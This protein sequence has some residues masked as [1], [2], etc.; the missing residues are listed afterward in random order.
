M[1]R[2]DAAAV[3][4]GGAWLSSPFWLEFIDP[5]YQFAL[6]ALGLLVLILTAYNKWLDSRIKRETLKELEE[7]DA[8]HTPH[9]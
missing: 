1:L 6:A 8:V 3:L 7:G 9:R 2:G 4:H 5:Y